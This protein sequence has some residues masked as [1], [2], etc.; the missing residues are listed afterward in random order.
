MLGIRE[1]VR[2]IDPSL[3]LADVS[4][5]EQVK[6]RNLSWVKQPTW[7]IGAFAGVAALLAALGLYGVLSHILRN[8]LAMVI[9][10]LATGLAGAF[11]LTRFMKSILF[12]VSALD[13]LALMQQ[14]SSDSPNFCPI[15]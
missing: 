12:G 15:Q 2:Q 9:V 1:A 4:T 10:G 6:T 7:V 8:A 13:P 5:M 11:A 14:L 3:P